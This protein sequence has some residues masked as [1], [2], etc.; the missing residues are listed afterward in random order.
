MLTLVAWEVVTGRQP[1]RCQTAAGVR[2]QNNLCCQYQNAISYSSSAIN[3][4][5]N[6]PPENVIG[7]D[8]TWLDPFPRTFM[9]RIE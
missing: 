6:D 4:T 8:S 3:C 9:T 5:V 1:L 7:V 2:R